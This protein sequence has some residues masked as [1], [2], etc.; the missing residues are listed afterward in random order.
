MPLV[1]KGLLNRES[2]PLLGIQGWPH[3]RIITTCL[4]CNIPQSI[5]T[6]PNTVSSPWEILHIPELL[7]IKIIFKMSN[8]HS[9]PHQTEM[10]KFAWGSFPLNLSLVPRDIK[11]R[12]IDD[13]GNVTDFAAHKALLAFIS[14]AFSELFYGPTKV[15]PNKIIA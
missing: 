11:F 4:G 14:G 5:L 2:C 7:Q 6:K 15:T 10:S 13:E 1:D 3:F 8:Y 9:I 12:V